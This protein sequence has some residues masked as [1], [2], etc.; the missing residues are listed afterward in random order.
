MLTNFW[1]DKWLNEG[2]LIYLMEV[3]Q[4][5]RVLT[6]KD[7]IILSIYIYIYTETTF[8]SDVNQRTLMNIRK[9][10]ELICN[11]EDRF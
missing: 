11:E 10:G 2:L 6:V 8:C 5:I 9:M 7:V 1:K 3:P 4:A